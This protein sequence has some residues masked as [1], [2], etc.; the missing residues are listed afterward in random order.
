MFCAFAVRRP[1]EAVLKLETHS[2]FSVYSPTRLNSLPVWLPPARAHGR[3]PRPLGKTCR[4]SRLHLPFPPPSGF[5]QQATLLLRLAAL[6]PPWLRAS[7]ALHLR[8]PRQLD[9][10]SH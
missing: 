9:G 5:A 10:L 2:T 6:L 3:G 8:G 1:T 4:W 7:S